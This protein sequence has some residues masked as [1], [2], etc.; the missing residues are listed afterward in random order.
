MATDPD[1]QTE[2]ADGIPKVYPSVRPFGTSTIFFGRGDDLVN[3]KVGEGEKLI[4]KLSANQTE[5]VVD[6]QFMENVYLKDGAMYPIDAPA[7]AELTIQ[8]IHPEY[9]VVVG[10]YSYSVP[11][12]GSIPTPMDTDDRGEIP[13][14]IIIRMTIKNSTGQ[15]KEDPPK[16][17]KVLGRIELF[18]TSTF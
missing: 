7:G 17:F 10:G 12:V 1:T 16:E 13:A 5:D 8:L 15:G 4:W 2:S 18:R 14:G 11:V 9:G 6:I 3:N